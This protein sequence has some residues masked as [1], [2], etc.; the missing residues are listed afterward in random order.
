MDPNHSAVIPFQVSL[1]N[2]ITNKI[3]EASTILLVEYDYSIKLE[4]KI[5]FI[6]SADLVMIGYLPQNLPD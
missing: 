6:E 3:L 1:P 2:F 5:V 4:N